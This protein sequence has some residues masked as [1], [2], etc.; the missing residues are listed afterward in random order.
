MVS[1]SVCEISP[2]LVWKEVHCRDGSLGWLI[3][4]KVV[5]ETFLPIPCQFQ[6]V[7][8]CFQLPEVWIIFDRPVF[9]PF[10][11]IPRIIICWRDWN[12]RSRKE[13]KACCRVC[14]KENWRSVRQC[15]QMFLFTTY[16]KWEKYTKQTQTIPNDPKMYQMAVK[17]TKGP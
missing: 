1:S 5:M 17:Q 4:S 2:R 9:V 11:P 12:K 13:L 3:T 8:S 7:P 16:Q 15:C 10:P 14:T 6:L